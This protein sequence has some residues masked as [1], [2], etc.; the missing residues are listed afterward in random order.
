[1]IL[2]GFAPWWPCEILCK[3]QHW[4]VPLICLPDHSLLETSLNRKSKNGREQF[5]EKLQTT[6]NCTKLG[7]RCI[8]ITNCSAWDEHAPA[9]AWFKWHKMHKYTHRYTPCDQSMWL[10]KPRAATSTTK[11]SKKIYT[12]VIPGS[13][14]LRTVLSDLCLKLILPFLLC[15]FIQCKR[16]LVEQPFQGFELLRPTFVAAGFFGGCPYLRPNWTE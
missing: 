15:V 11:Y 1:M 6:A 5:C 14:V 8:N 16:E 2:P 12:W 13:C 9:D 7:R 3:L 10:W 4:T